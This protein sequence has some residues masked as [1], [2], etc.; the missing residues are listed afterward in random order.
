MN[1]SD[2]VETLATRKRISHHA[3][4]RVINEIFRSM[5]DTL[6]MVSKESSQL[7]YRQHR[8]PGRQASTIGQTNQAF[9]TAKW[10]A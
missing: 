10:P 4:D 1:K 5:T 3:A 9:E 7:Y 6:A 8:L 2:L